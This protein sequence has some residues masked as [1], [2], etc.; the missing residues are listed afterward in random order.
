ME[1]SGL[2]GLAHRTDRKMVRIEYF[3]SWSEGLE[4]AGLGDGVREA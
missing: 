1:E 2:R 3:T 4:V